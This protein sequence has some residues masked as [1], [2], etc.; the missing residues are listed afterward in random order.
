MEQRIAALEM[1]ILALQQNN[2]RLASEL[3][4]RGK[5]EKDEESRLAADLRDAQG[6]LA[7]LR[8]ELAAMA[9]TSVAREEELSNLQATLGQ[10]Y[11]ES[12]AKVVNLFQHCLHLV[13][14][15]SYPV[16]RFCFDS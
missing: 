15:D 6:Q 11:A 16:V 9:A 8:E 4:H 1:E 5:A 12:D 10:F 7:V 14:F 2:A 13:L 3:E